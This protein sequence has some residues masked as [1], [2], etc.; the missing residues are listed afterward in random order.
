MIPC[1]IGLDLRLQ[2]VLHHIVSDVDGRGEALGI[3]RHHGS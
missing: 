1:Q 2:A 3:R